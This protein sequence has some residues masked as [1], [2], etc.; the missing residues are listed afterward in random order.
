MGRERVGGGREGG[1]IGRRGVERKKK[2]GDEKE[3]GKKRERRKGGARNHIVPHLLINSMLMAFSCSALCRSA[4][5]SVSAA[6][7]TLRL[8]QRDS[9][10]MVFSLPR[11]Y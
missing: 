7:S 2:R 8:L 5:T 4:S 3:V 11:S 9:S 1:R 10:H 6:L